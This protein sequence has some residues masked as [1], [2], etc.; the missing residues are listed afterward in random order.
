[1]SPM[2]Y[3]SGLSP[4]S[5]ALALFPLLL[6]AA[7]GHSGDDEVT[8]SSVD[9]DAAASS[10]LGNQI[11]VD[12]D[13]AS[14]NQANSAVAANYPNGELPAALK[15]PEAIGRAQAKAM[16]L[17]GGPGKLQ[18]APKAVELAGTL[19]SDSAYSTA[20][21]IAARP[22]NQD[23]TK[24]VDYT[25]QWAAKL[26]A[27]FP[28][29]PQGAVQEAAGTNDGG[30]SLRV[31][32]FLTPVP[33]GDVV[34]FYYTRAAGAAYKL[35][36]LKDGASDVLAGVKGNSAVTVYLRPTGSGTTQVDLV[37]TGT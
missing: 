22:G 25:A 36:H 23:C 34:D 28:V 27:A 26:P 13:L 18:K 2:R 3:L 7:C 30:C 29:Y 10:A 1:M 4:N 16:N 17:V 21:R 15:S 32:S 33:V 14:Q 11:M 35:Q 24:K 19:P 8:D 6:L 12:P 9:R 37:T 20:A 31:V 5:V